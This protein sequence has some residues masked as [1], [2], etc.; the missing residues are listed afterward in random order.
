MDFK[1]RNTD[2]EGESWDR[3]MSLLLEGVSRRFI[4]LLS[5][6]RVRQTRKIA[7]AACPRNM[8]L[9]L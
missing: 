6:V 7:V 4:F 9:L 5:T 8:Y 1:V 2:P 3:K